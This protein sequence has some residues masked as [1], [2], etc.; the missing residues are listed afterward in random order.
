MEKKIRY[1]FVWSFHVQLQKYLRKIHVN[2]EGTSNLKKLQHNS[3]IFSNRSRLL[4]T[5]QQEVGKL[6][7][8]SNIRT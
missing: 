3:G 7:G 2:D 8:S 4:Q 6:S 5:I 1:L